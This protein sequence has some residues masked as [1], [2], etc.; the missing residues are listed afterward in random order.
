MDAL[1]EVCERLLRDSNARSVVVLGE[2]ERVIASA[3]SLLLDPDAG[4]P[5]THVSMITPGV[6]LVVS[7][8][9][10]SSLGLVRLRVSKAQE[11]LRRL[12]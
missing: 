2:H 8:D 1:Q 12:V 5:Q 7:F 6:V 10:R 9:F 4:P 11:Q 3:G